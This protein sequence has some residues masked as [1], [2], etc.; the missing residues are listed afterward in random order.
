MMQV[1]CE[2]HPL[3]FILSQQ[4]LNDSTESQKQDNK[5]WWADFLMDFS[6][7]QAIKHWI[8]IRNGNESNS[9]TDWK[10]KKIIQ[11]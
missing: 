1:Y 11:K 2:I 6:V 10:D 3:M 5:L 8:R 7:F 9:Y 4:H